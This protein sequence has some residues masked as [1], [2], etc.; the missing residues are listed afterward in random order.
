ML[1]VQSAY[2]T[3]QCTIVADWGQVHP[4]LRKI[5]HMFVRLLF[6]F[7]LVAASQVGAQTTL[8][9]GQVHD[10]AGE[11][12]V[13][14]NIYLQGTYEGTS[15]D[16]EGSYQLKTSL[17][18]SQLLIVS[19]LGYQET[20]VPL[21]LNGQPLQHTLILHADATELATITVNAGTFRAGDNQRGA[22]LSS[23]DIVTTAG[24][25]GDITAALQTLPGTTPVGEDGQLFVRGGAAHET[26]TFVD[27]LPTAQPYSSSVPN[28]PGRG[29]FSPFLFKGTTFS[30]GGY[31]A[32]Y[33]QALSSALLLETEDLAP[34]TVTAINLMSVGAGV[35]HTHRGEHH[36][37][38]AAVDHTNLS[39]YLAVLPN[40]LDWQRAPQGT[41]GLLTYRY[42]PAAGHTLKVQ[43]QWQQQQMAIRNQVA[44]RET[45]QN[46]TATWQKSLGNRWGLYLGSTYTRHQENITTAEVTRQ[47]NLQHSASKVKLHYAANKQVL[48]RAGA[49]YWY[50]DF[51]QLTVVDGDQWQIGQQDRYTAAFA[52][53]EWQW[54]QRWAMR[55]GGRWEHSTRTGQSAVSPRV[56]VAYRLG[57][58]GQVETAYGQFVQTP[59]PETATPAPFERARHALLNYQWQHDRR[60][61]RVEAY[62]KQYQQLADEG[63]GYAQGIDVFYRDQ[64]TLPLTDFWVSYSLLDTRRQSAALSVPYTPTFAS[65]HNLAL[66]AKRWIAAWNCQI[67][68]TF[69]YGSPRTYDDPNTATYNDGRT[70]PYRDLSLNASWLTRWWGHFT[71]IHL[72]VTNVPGFKNEFGRRYSPMPAADGTYSSIAVRP[73]AKRFAFIGIFVSLE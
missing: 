67:G 68:T 23:L 39:P 60:T 59:T 4:S 15:T 40:R 12:I 42:Q 57:Q 13:G 58:H 37:W 3:I 16:T 32:E 73:P 69:R 30:S 18:D 64:R 71:I 38:Q 10:A 34:A 36:S 1:T 72:S 27:G 49:E 9:T 46:G 26:R 7:L 55:G 62:H 50:E 33:G 24:A 63:S 20:R 11:A 70:L 6:L 56:A 51:S 43:T 61:I 66:V 41:N 65:T 48:L 29:R 21:W 54:G 14:A 53:G 5:R 17:R 2:S 31:S 22:V 47:E 8:L 45:Y 35:S 44:L 52:E 25:T 28:L 19:Y